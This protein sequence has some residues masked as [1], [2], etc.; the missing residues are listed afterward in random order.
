MI[1]KKIPEK[2]MKKIPKLKAYP[3]FIYCEIEY[4]TFLITVVTMDML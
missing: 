3:L 4:I 2:K 1:L